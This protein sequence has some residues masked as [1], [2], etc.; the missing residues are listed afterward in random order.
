M[1]NLAHLEILKNTTD[2]EH[3]LFYMNT[4]IP[5]IDY[6]E[7]RFPGRTSE[8]FVKSFPMFFMSLAKEQQESLISLH[9]NRVAE[10]G[11]ETELT[12]PNILEVMSLFEALDV[13]LLKDKIDWSFL[14][15]I[16]SELGDHFRRKVSNVTS[17]PSFQVFVQMDR[18]ARKAMIYWM[19]RRF[20]EK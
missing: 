6:I 8:E 19:H 12:L 15:E 17:N 10:I 5:L 2:A 20:H 11:G 16:F 3:M 7:L 1:Q 14:D 13:E 18:S 9:N 4:Y